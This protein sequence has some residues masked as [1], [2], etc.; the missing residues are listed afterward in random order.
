MA[1]N[2]QT[3]GMAGQ[4][5]EE[6]DR[7]LADATLQQDEAALQ[8][9]GKAQPKDKT[10]QFGTDSVIKLIFKYSLPSIVAQIVS[11]SYNLINMSFIGRSVGSLG[12]AAIAICNPITMIQ[13]SLNSLMGQG[14]AAAVAI[15]LGKGDRE[16]A[17][18]LLGTGVTFTW[19]FA[20]IN[21]IVGHM[22]MEPLLVAFGASEAI[23]PLAK[24]YLNITLFGMLIGNFTSL[25]P[26]MRIEGYPS[27]A[28]ITMLLSTTMN[29][30]FTPTFLFVFH[31]GIRGAAFGTLC[32]Q[33]ASSIW[34]LSFLTN[35]DRAVGLKWRHMRVRIDRMLYIMQLGLPNF[36]MSVTNSMLSVTMNR[37]LGAYGGDISIS[38]WG[39]SNSINNLI[40]QPIFGMNQGVQPIVGYNIG[41]KK[42]DRVKEALLCSLGIATAFATLGWLVT[43]FFPAQILSFFNGDPELVAIG[44]QILIV[45]RM[46]VCIVGVQQSGSAYFQ[47]IG[48]PIT[49]TLLTLSRQVLILI[50]CVLI[51]PQYFG[52][53]GILY[54]GPVSDFLSTALTGGFLLHEIRGLNRMIK[55]QKMIEGAGA[56]FVLEGAQAAD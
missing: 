25:N 31:L 15:S 10:E 54:S 23:L 45:F 27:R 18:A 24:Q 41:A 36:L 37:T 11:T 1:D 40:N 26:M 34:M 7:R 47:Y 56:G 20:L 19:I 14:A 4:S 9:D 21:C 48:K 39:V 43:R 35:K 5:P 50:P 49:S 8:P 29:V 6:K 51:L 13:G 33:L 30:I 12:I 53:N 17:R 46:F 16:G 2:E 38:A 22:F 42:Y 3:Q 32:G 55:E 44:T 52:F 28:M